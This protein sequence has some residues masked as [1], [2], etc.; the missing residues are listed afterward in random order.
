[1]SDFEARDYPGGPLV[2]DS[3]QTISGT[4]YLDRARFIVA[5]EACM[6]SA[7]SAR[8]GDAIVKVH[9]SRFRMA[10]E[11]R[12]AIRGAWGVS[13]TQLEVQDWQELLHTMKPAFPPK[14][15]VVEEEETG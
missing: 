6:L 5:L 13:G 2:V 14:M 8:L 1:M 10:T 9:P 11:L 15:E 7:R 3:E 4:I 12:E